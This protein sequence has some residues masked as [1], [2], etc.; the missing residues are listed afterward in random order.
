MN[1]CY[2][3]RLPDDLLCMIFKLVGDEVQA[4]YDDS[5]NEQ[6]NSTHWDDW[7][8]N[9]DYYDI[10]GHY[11]PATDR[12]PSESALVS[13]E[14]VCKRWKCVLLQMPSLWSVLQISFC[15]GAASLE[16]A[17]T[18]LRRSGTHP[19]KIT[20]LWDD[21]A[22]INP[23]EIE[24]K[25]PIEGVPLSHQA[26]MAGIHLVF[27]MQE[28]YAHV[29]RWREFTL[30]TT[31][32]VH[33]I[34]ALSVMSRP[35]VHPASMLEKL[36]LQLVHNG[37]HAH[38][39]IHDP[40]LFPGSAPPIRDL[41]LFGI[42]CAWLSSSMLSSHVVNLQMHYDDFDLDDDI[43]TVLFSQL[44][45]GLSN[46]Q[47]LSL[48][49]ELDVGILESDVGGLI[50]LPQ[51]R[52]LAIKSRSMAHWVDFLHNV[53]MPNLRILTLDGIGPQPGP[54]DLVTIIAELVRLTDPDI[55]QDPTRFLLEL[56]ELHLLHFSHCTDSALVHLLYKQMTTVKILTLG[57]GASSK[58]IML[59]KGLLPTPDG[60]G[61]L[62]LPGLRTLIV[63]DLPERLM[64]R[65]VCKR[66]LVAGPLEELYYY[67]DQPIETDDWPV[68]RVYE[69][70]DVES[71]RYCDIVSRHWW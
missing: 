19:L 22:W 41:L 69:I 48:E 67:I 27:L 70:A 44:S 50:T 40:S 42:N 13:A 60:L 23:D 61:D 65:L 34:Q 14:R 47:S 3:H 8:D 31:S 53:R 37:E 25:Y 63:F 10:L 21:L 43:R 20:L 18:F 9:E 28:L 26:T 58:N 5:F 55:M 68:E 1:G 46:L 24:D 2:I 57:P 16:H 33:T 6:L 66:S 39:Y 49:L 62:P 35:S 11:R 64:R 45:G 59:A 36:H 52:S 12:P 15:E 38:H 32:V 29:H 54:S 17:Q 56:D 71:Y 7:G 51:L 30:R 4:T